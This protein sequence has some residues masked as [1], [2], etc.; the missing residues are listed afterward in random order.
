MNDQQGNMPSRRR[1]APLLLLSLAAHV[2]AGLIAGVVIV[3]RRLSPPST[4]VPIVKSVSIP[5]T[6][7]LNEAASQ[8]TEGSSA[9][10]TI[11][12]EAI[13]MAIQDL[14]F[15]IASVPGPQT[16]RHRSMSENLV[17]SSLGPSGVGIGLGVNVVGDGGGGKAEK[18]VPSF[19]GIKAPGERIVLMFDISKTVST[20]AAKAGMSMERIRDET[21]KLIDS[22]GV[23]T[24][25]NLVQFARNYVFFRAKLA[26]ASRSNRDAAHLW[27]TRFFGTHGTLPSGIPSTVS[28]SPGFLVAL[29]EVFK[30]EPD[31]IIIISDGDMQRGTTANAT[32]PMK[33]IENTIAQLQSGRATGARI[34]FI[35]VGA[36]KTAADGLKQILARYGFGGVYTELK[37]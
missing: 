29:S 28:G 30:L 35:G 22:L 26:P 24:R 27:L 20:A 14:A 3:V 9:S 5:K 15:S 6:E 1:L 32:I 19:M 13:S 31:S 25:F 12:R 16:E 4:T 10:A 7:D 21:R 2:A 23:N 36:K 11:Q 37:N 17:Q 33:E 34:H 18:S 8:G